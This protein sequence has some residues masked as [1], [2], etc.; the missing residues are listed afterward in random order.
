MEFS[1]TIKKEI[2]FKNY[3]GGGRTN[4]KLGSYK[5]KILNVGWRLLCVSLNADF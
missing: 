2:F 4:V 1:D 3:L 5:R